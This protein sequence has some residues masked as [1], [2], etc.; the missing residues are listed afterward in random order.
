MSTQNSLD[1]H[2][3]MTKGR[4][5]ETIIEEL[6]LANDYEVHRFG[7]ENMVPGLVRRLRYNDSPV[8]S[9]IKKMPDFIM[10]KGDQIHFVEVKYR[11]DG[12]FSYEHLE[13]DDKVYPYKDCILILVSRDKIKA[14]SVKELQS[15][16]TITAECNNYLGYR[17]EFGLDQ[18][19]IKDNLQIVKVFFQNAPGK[20]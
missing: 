18:Q 4:L 6:F 20:L 1:Y 9:Q 12:K 14:L 10:K 15:G 7:M 13:K 16:Q 19:T 5:A 3:Q 8:S 11:S 2:Y 17:K